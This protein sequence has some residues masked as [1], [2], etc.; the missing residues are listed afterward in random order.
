MEEFDDLD[1][2]HLRVLLDPRQ[3]CVS[4]AVKCAPS[5]SC[6]P[7]VKTA[8][9]VRIKDRAQLEQNNSKFMLELRELLEILNLFS[10]VGSKG[11]TFPLSLEV[12]DCGAITETLQIKLTIQKV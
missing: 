9:T 5:F 12:L 6:V 2:K 4:P 10:I 1:P 8:V 7:P 3:K 11:Q